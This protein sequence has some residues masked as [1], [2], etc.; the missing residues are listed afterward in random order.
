MLNGRQLEERIESFLSFII[1]F[2]ETIVFD[3]VFDHHDISKSEM[4]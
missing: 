1:A 4:G 2:Y 3:G